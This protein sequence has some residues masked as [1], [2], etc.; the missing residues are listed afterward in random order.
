MVWL[1][2]V[3]ASIAW[4]PAVAVAASTLPGDIKWLTNESVGSGL[5]FAASQEG[6]N[7]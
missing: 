6:R 3:F 4:T 5:C 7:F 1:G 2:I